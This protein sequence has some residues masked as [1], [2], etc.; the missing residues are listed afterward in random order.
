MADISTDEQVIAFVNSLI[1]EHFPISDAPEWV[2]YPLF[3]I[4]KFNQL[5]E[6]LKIFIQH[7]DE[8]CDANLAFGYYSDLIDT[9]TGAMHEAISEKCTVIIPKEL[10]D[11]YMK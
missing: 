4:E 1:D 6:N 3:R 2:N 11:R 7:T 10:Y 5:M 9:G 8:Y